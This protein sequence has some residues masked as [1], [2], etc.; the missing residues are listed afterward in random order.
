MRGVACLSC[1]VLALAMSD[2]TSWSR[3]L[4][5]SRHSCFSPELNGLT[6]ASLHLPKT[7]IPTSCRTRRDR[8]ER[9]TLSMEV[10][11]KEDRRQ[12]LLA[13]RYFVSRSS[14]ILDFIDS[15]NRTS[16]CSTD[17]CNGLLNVTGMTSSSLGGTVRCLVSCSGCSK[18][19]LEFD[20]TA[21]MPSSKRTQVAFGLKVAMVVSGKVVAISRVKR[22]KTF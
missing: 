17:G 14:A 9:T 18:R 10:V 4:R 8:V 3:V 11:T 2:V 16:K 22:V 7:A 21:D 19:T 6:R 20:S 13:S 5:C 1:W 12:A 15:I